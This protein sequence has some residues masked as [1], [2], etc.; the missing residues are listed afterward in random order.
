M[1]EQLNHIDNYKHLA[2]KSKL[3]DQTT[4]TPE[5]QILFSEPEEFTTEIDGKS[6][7]YY[8]IY[9]KC[10][11]KPDEDDDFESVG[12][13]IL[14]TPE[15]LFSYGVSENKD[16]T[17]N[18]Q[19]YSF[20]IVL[21]DREKPT[22]EQKEFVILIRRITEVVKKHLI[23][24]GEQIGKYDLDERDLSKLNQKMTRK[25]LDPLYTKYEKSSNGQFV[26]VA[27][28]TPVLY[29]KIK[30]YAKNDSFGTKF[31][32]ASESGE[33]GEDVF[34]NP[35]DM[36]ST[37]NEKKY[38]RAQCAIQIESIFS[39]ASGISLQIKLC[40]S[41]VEPIVMEQKT[42]LKRE[43]R[44]NIEHHTEI[45]TDTTEHVSTNPLQIKKEHD[46][47]SIAS[48]S[49]DEPIVEKLKPK[50]KAS[51]STKTSKKPTSKPTSKPRIVKDPTD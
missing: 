20:P 2:K 1:S 40:D 33:N 50:T 37:E 19:G 7:I 45:I 42:Y 36:I 17:G 4:F 29:P 44:P 38:Y 22:D 10:L 32:H 31:V 15:N 27:G 51:S 18:V 41:L 12:D 47:S 25:G 13:F 46:S 14:S 3:I 23:K 26:E 21:Y 39:G 48:D 49:D 9:M 6:V 5:E 43:P 24:V 35:R 8:R 11:N 30:Y 16:K 28:S 34:I